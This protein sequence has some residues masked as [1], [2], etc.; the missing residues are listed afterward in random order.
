MDFAGSRAHPEPGRHTSFGSFFKKKCCI[1]II[2]NRFGDGNCNECINTHNKIS[3]DFF[4]RPCV[5][6]A[7]LVGSIPQCLKLQNFVLNR[8]TVS[9]TNPSK[10]RGITPHGINITISSL[11]GIW[12]K[13]LIGV[14]IISGYLRKSVHLFH[15]IGCHH[16]FRRKAPPHRCN[17]QASC[18]T[19]P[20][21]VVKHGGVLFCSSC[22]IAIGICSTRFSKNSRFIKTGK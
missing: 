20:E 7:Y 3:A 9:F 22:K 2:A 17:S 8:L 10:N 5:V 15:D 12:C 4:P 1:R 11:H 18:P 13:I 19:S 14:V 6:P 16:L 21:S